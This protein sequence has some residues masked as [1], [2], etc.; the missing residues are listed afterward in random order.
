M[1]AT[2]HRD[3][4]SLFHLDLPEGEGSA[5]FEQLA[6][7]VDFEDVTGGRA[8]NHL[9]KP[10]EMGVP[11]VRTTTRY[12]RPAHTFSAV[13]DDLVARLPERSFNHAL[14]EIYDQRYRKM[15]YHSDQSLDLAE[16]S[17]IAL[18]SVYDRALCASGR[19]M[20]QLMVRSKETGER[21]SIP[22]GH[23]S[24]VL[25]SVATNARYAH[26]IVLPAVAPE[27]TRWLGL[28]LRRSKTFVT[29]R[30]GEPTLADGRAL[31]LAD[32]T[33]RK[34]FYRLRGQENRAVDFRYPS[35]SYT[36]SEADRLLPTS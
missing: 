16:G 22:L 32:V 8:G 14:I 10:G 23:G 27:D 12:L 9:T 33:E 34:A 13:H 17:H 5:L 28:T 2:F 19:G 36:I 35:L 3:G 29:F 24:V 20:R 31:T 18:V 30:D 6:A 1:D 7:S 21:F 26:K 15:G 4:F 25:F 11:I